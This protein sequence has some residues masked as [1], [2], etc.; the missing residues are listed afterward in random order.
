[1]AAP[2]GRPDLRISDAGPAP[3]EVTA[4]HLA[5]EAVFAE[6]Q[7]R[8]A[9]RTC[10][11]DW[12]ETWSAY[13]EKVLDWRF[14]ILRGTALFGLYECNRCGRV[15]QMPPGVLHCFFCDSAWAVYA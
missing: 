6:H 14:A 8:R 15:L 3:A 7:E 13:R 11:W 4:R 2:P 9:V 1:M 5:R 12:A 10:Q